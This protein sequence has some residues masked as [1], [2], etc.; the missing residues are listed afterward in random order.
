MS[1]AIADDD[2]GHGPLDHSAENVEGATRGD[3][4]EVRVYEGEMRS[5]SQRGD[6]VFGM[7]KAGSP[8]GAATFC[9]VRL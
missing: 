1:S 7:Q 6:S 4:F 5:A 9:I 8:I 3:A 2:I